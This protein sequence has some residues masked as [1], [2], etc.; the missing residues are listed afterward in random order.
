[1]KN[2]FSQLPW[3]DLCLSGCDITPQQDNDHN[4]APD[5]HQNLLILW[6]A[7]NLNISTFQHQDSTAFVLSLKPHLGFPSE[8]TLKRNLWLLYAFF[9]WNLWFISFKICQCICS[10]VI[11]IKSSNALYLSYFHYVR[12]AKKKYFSNETDILASNF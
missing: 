4:D 9:V 7:Y 10:S 1:M 5:E 12:L 2:S 3:G 11:L 6:H 8:K